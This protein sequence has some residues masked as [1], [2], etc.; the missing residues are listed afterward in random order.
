MPNHET[1]ECTCNISCRASSQA[2]VVLIVWLNRRNVT[3]ATLTWQFSTDENYLHLFT[4]GID[5]GRRGRSPPSVYQQLYRRTPG[6]IISSSP[7]A[8]AWLELIPETTVSISLPAAL[9]LDSG[10]DWHLQDVSKTERAKM[11]SD[12][13]MRSPLHRFLC[14][15]IRWTSLEEISVDVLEKSEQPQ[16]SSTMCLPWVSVP[17]KFLEHRFG[18]TSFLQTLFWQFQ[19][20]TWH[21]SF[22]Q[23][24]LPTGS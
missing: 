18:S 19:R 24:Q 22:W 1:W 20:A 8:N 21:A 10:F 9:Q 14:V 11:R 6:A 23:Y 15:V 2:V 7:P 17:D 16:C 3:C 4:R 12:H 13:E 5:V